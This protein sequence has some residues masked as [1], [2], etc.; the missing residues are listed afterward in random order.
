MENPGKN[1]LRLLLQPGDVESDQARAVIARAAAVL[2]EGGTVAFPTE[3]VYGL[4]ANAL[5]ADAV[6]KIFLAKQRPP[7]DPLI[8]HISDT[9]MLPLVTADLPEM[10]QRLME[11]FWPGPLTLL[12]PRGPRIPDA[13]TAGRPRVGIRMPESPVAQ[14]LVRAAGVPVAAPS[15]N[16]F[17]RPSP[18]RAA[19]VIEDLDG[20]ID[21]LLDAGETAHGL[22]STVVDPCEDPCIVYRPGVITLEQIRAVARGAVAYTHQ[23]DAAAPAALPSP[24]VGMRHYAPR[25]RLVLVEAE[26]PAPFL[27]F[28]QAAEQAAERRERLGLMLPDSFQPAAAGI[29]ATIFRWGSWSQPE[30]LAQR[31]FAGLRELDAAGVETIL[32]PLPT[33]QGLGAAIRDRL[34]KAARPK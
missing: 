3:T 26:G 31:L 25:A 9:S 28:R 11:V 17:G 2:R 8:V 5:D 22:E 27:A 6:A 21:A 1:T 13:V 29:P 34:Q 14:A 16:S 4:G 18:T 20:R 33:A 23:V 32:C 19:H 7:W 30:T 12:V 15:A 24:G 10:A